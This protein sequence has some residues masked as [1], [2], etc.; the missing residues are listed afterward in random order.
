MKVLICSPRYRFAALPN[1]FGHSED[2][3]LQLR[4]SL[5]LFQ[6]S[7]LLSGE[8][9]QSQRLLNNW[10]GN[11]KQMWR[12]L[13]RAS[14]HGYSAESFHSHCDGHSPTFVVILVKLNPAS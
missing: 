4:T 12:L 11:P 9:L 13:Y 3:K 1:K 5:K 6:G 8:K 7:Q 10:F 2:K 14:T